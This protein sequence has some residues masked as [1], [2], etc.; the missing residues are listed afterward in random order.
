MK[1]KPS[2]PDNDFVP[3]T[4]LTRA[5]RRNLGPAE[6]GS[7]AGIVVFE[8]KAPV[9]PGDPS[10]ITVGKGILKWDRVAGIAPEVYF[11]RQLDPLVFVLS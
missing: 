9:V 3:V 5:G 7:I 11:F 6:H 8:K 2:I 1:A 10:V 4:E